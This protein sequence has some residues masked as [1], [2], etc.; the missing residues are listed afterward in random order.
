MSLQVLGSEHASKMID[1]AFMKVDSNCDGTVSWD[2]YLSYIQ[3]RYTEQ[4]HKYYSANIRPFPGRCSK[5]GGRVQHVCCSCYMK[6][7]PGRTISSQEYV[8][9]MVIYEVRI[10]SSVVSFPPAFPSF[11]ELSGAMYFF[12][13]P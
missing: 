7:L 11:Q 13:G 5:V 1:D 10:V 4:D 12:N 2:E 9:V 3:L 6:E 8:C